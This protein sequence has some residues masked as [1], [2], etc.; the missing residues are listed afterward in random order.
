MNRFQKAM[1]YYR[2]Q[3]RSRVRTVYYDGDYWLTD[4]RVCHR[5][6]ESEMELNP[7]ILKESPFEDEVKNLFALTK[8][9]NEND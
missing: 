2:K 5:I 1:D 6:P 7:A 3:Y 9:G 8:K 4:G